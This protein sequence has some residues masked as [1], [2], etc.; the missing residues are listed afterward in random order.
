MFTLWAVVGELATI[1]VV[2]DEIRAGGSMPAAVVWVIVVVLVATGASL[3][4]LALRRIREILEETDERVV[5]AR[6][7]RGEA[8]HELRSWLVL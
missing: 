5:R 3:F 4:L 7:P 2:F 8:P 1:G 6:R